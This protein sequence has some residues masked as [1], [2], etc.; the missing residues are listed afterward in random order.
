L[1]GPLTEPQIMSILP[2]KV[3]QRHL[4]TRAANVWD[5]V[6]SDQSPFQLNLRVDDAYIVDEIY[7][8]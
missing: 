7:T 8:L 6:Q 3:C 5:F 1:P 4:E 2:S